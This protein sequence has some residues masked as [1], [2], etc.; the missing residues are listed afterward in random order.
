MYAGAHN[1]SKVH[2]TVCL[3]QSNFYWFC[4]NVLYIQQFG[5]VR[6]LVAEPSFRTLAFVLSDN[7]GILI[8]DLVAMGS[9][10]PRTASFGPS[11]VRVPSILSSISN[12][13]LT[14]GVQIQA[15]RKTQPSSVKIIKTSTC[16]KHLA[17]GKLDF[18]PDICGYHRG[19]TWPMSTT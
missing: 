6:G 3:V 4:G 2:D 14:S 12:K 13:P 9:P 15:L 18:E 5:S 17:S 7:V 19:G 1:R 16:M 11:A 8:T 10:A